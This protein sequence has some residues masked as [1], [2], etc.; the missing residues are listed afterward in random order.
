MA[1]VAL[2]DLLRG[3]DPP[4]SCSRREDLGEGIHAHDAPVD[5][6]AQER[7]DKRVDKFFVRGGGRNSGGVGAGIGLHLEKIVWLVFKNVKIV[8][9]RTTIEVLAALGA[10]CSACG[11][12]PAGNG[13]EQK[14]LVST[15]GLLIP[16]AE[17]A[18]KACGEEALRVHFDADDTDAHGTCGF[19][20]GGEGVFFGEDEVAAG[21]EHT[22]GHVEGGGVAAGEDALPVLIGGVVDE[23]KG[24]SGQL[25]IHWITQY[26]CVFCDESQ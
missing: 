20:G 4:D 11:I 12:L 8:F 1:D 24:V 15:S 6:H 18:V 7:G 23:L 3:C 10:L 13:V 2:D 16:G 21:G 25:F 17:D 9:L 26:L 5:V 22:E 19:D 14:G